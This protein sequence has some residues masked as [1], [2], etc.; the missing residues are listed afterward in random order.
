MV[1]ASIAAYGAVIGNDNINNSDF[2]MWKR[3]SRNSR[4]KLVDAHGILCMYL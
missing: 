4:V 1:E 3:A 2:C